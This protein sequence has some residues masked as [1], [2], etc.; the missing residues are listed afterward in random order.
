[1]KGGTLGVTAAERVAYTA[2]R[3]L[4]TLAMPHHEHAK[5]PWCEHGRA[6]LAREQMAAAEGNRHLEANGVL[7]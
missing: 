2:T 5:N 3:R 4:S 7:W 1:M 6:R